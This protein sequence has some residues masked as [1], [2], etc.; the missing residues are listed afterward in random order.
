MIK[1][2]TDLLA[3]DSSQAPVVMHDLANDDYHGEKDHISRSKAHRYRGSLGGRAQWYEE[4][5]GESCFSGN[6]STDFGSL[7]D[8]MFEARCHGMDVE[9]AA[10]VP[11]REVLTS[12]GQRRGGRYQ[13][14]KATLG[15][16]QIECKED[17]FARALCVVEAILDHRLARELV[18]GTTHTQESVFWVDGD[19]NKRKAR[20]DG[21]YQDRHWYDLKTTSKDL[22]DMR[23]SF[24]RFGYGWQAAWYGEAASLAGCDE[25]G[26]FPFIVATTFPPYDVAVIYLT[27]ES[28]DAAARE[29]RETLDA[30]RRR[31]DSGE[32]VG[33]DYHSPLVLDLA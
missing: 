19:G 15:P 3:V 32:Y 6:S 28:I 2:S 13:E 1:A 21:R 12:N 29:I 24:R 30:I 8:A 31:R 23:Y 33:D 14:W 22:A 4:V 10:I 27:Q 20:C 9:T 25:P 16:G 5:Q 26:R 11:P 18:E 17:D 7:V